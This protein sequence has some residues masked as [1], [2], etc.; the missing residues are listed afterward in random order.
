[1]TEFIYRLGMATGRDTDEGRAFLKAF[2][3][4]PEAGAG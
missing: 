4:G 3:A 2:R 1:M